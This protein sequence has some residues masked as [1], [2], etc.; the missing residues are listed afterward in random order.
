M[1]SVAKVVLS[2]LLA[3]ALTGL[4]YVISFCFMALVTLCTHNPA[5][6][7]PIAVFLWTCCVWAFQ[8]VKRPIA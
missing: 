5:M 6:G 1:E 7:L 4:L 2:F 8:V 3:T